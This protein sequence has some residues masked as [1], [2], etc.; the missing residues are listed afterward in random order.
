MR[1]TRLS[2]LVRQG[3]G[4]MHKN[5]PVPTDSGLVS[6][7]VP[8]ASLPPASPLT[9]KPKT[10]SR[11]RVSFDVIDKIE[12]LAVQLLSISKSKAE[13]EAIMREA[14]LQID[15]CIESIASKH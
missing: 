5:G 1:T 14:L 12:L 11:P 3:R 15:K 2:E 6:Q 4:A 7:L 9:V 13:P 10:S 8:E